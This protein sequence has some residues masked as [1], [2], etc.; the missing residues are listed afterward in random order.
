MSNTMSNMATTLRARH[1]GVTT[2]TDGPALRSQ[3]YI[4]SSQASGAHPT[5]ASQSHLHSGWLFTSGSNT[6]H[7]HL[8][9]SPATGVPGGLAWDVPFDREDDDAKASRR[10]QPLHAGSLDGRR[11][12]DADPAK[13]RRSSSAR[14]N[15][16]AVSRRFRSMSP[17]VST[18]RSSSL[19]PER[20]G[21]SYRPSSFSQSSSGIR[22]S[23]ANISGGGMR[24]GK[25]HLRTKAEAQQEA[26]ESF[27]QAHTF[28]PILATDRSCSS[29]I[30]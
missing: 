5:K 14:A 4:S 28:Q 24:S 19:S 11:T 20:P 29:A 30:G 16:P 17:P 1:D 6:C 12:S 10:K 22:S 2:G 3:R 7:C 9:P 13:K 15:P 8:D 23:S 25:K 18:Q 27:R 21:R 26:L